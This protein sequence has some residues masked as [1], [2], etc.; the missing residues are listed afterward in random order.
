MRHETLDSKFQT[1]DARRYA[2]TDGEAGS[3]RLLLIYTPP[4][5]VEYLR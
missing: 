3:N 2:S 5:W 4:H 1:R